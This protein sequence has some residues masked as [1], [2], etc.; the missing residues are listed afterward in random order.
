MEGLVAFYIEEKAD[1][2][3]LGSLIC[4]KALREEAEARGGILPRLTEEF[5]KGY[6]EKQEKIV[7]KN[8]D[9]EPWQP[10]IKTKTGLEMRRQRIVILTSITP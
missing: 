1:Q 6:D 10:D 5:V 7:E 2:M 8:L 4:H 3:F 9:E